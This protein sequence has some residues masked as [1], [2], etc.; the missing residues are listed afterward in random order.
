[1]LW[2]NILII[3]IIKRGSTVASRNTEVGYCSMTLYFEHCWVKRLENCIKHTVIR[4][5]LKEK[6]SGG[7]VS[8]EC[9]VPQTLMAKPHQFSRLHSCFTGDKLFR[10]YLFQSQ[11]ILPVLAPI[12]LT[13]SVCSFA[14]ENIVFVRCPWSSEWR[15]DTLQIQHLR[16]TQFFSCNERP[17]RAECHV[18]QLWRRARMSRN[19]IKLFCFFYTFTF[20]F[21]LKRKKKCLG[22]FDVKLLSTSWTGRNCTL[23]HL[24]NKSLISVCF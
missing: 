23:S 4:K 1:M 11:W 15:E 17:V 9:E 12:L 6:G 19:Y 18:C 3:I 21:G 5:R 10:P 22:F 14:L 13:N 7:K 2:K 24:V 20:T 16:P 8:E